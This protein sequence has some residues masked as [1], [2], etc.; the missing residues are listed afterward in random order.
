MKIFQSPDLPAPKSML[1][2]TAEANNISA[3]VTA[4]DKYTKEMDQVGG[5]WWGQAMPRI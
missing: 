2:A 1:R 3:Q 4:Y 5:P